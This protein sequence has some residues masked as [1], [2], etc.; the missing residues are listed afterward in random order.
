ME[1]MP[2]RLAGPA[3]KDVVA[4]Q[5]RALLSSIARHRTFA[6]GEMLW[7]EGDTNG[8]LVAIES[9]QVKIFRLLATGHPVTIYL[10]GPGEV[11]GFM[12]FL[13][14]GPYPANAQALSDVEAAVVSRAALLEE[15]RRNPELCMGLTGLLARRLRD[16]F[17]RIKTSSVP[18]VLTRVA[19]AIVSLV[20]EGAP[21]SLAIVDL[22]VQAAEFAGAIGIAPESFSRGVTKLVDAGVLHRV[23]ARRLQV[24]GLGRLRRIALGHGELLGAADDAEAKQAR[25]Q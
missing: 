9:G 11:F 7:R 15:I 18:E 6:A 17:D 20:P 22:P 1:R 19:A 23:G 5:V 12:P 2:M 25:E 3:C 24:L 4:D 10:F 14:G 8:M 16:A 21:E 13:D